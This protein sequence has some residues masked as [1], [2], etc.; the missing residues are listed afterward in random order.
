MTEKDRMPWKAAEK[1]AE[2]GTYKMNDKYT[3][4]EISRFLNISKSA[5]RYY[6]SIGLCEPAC[7]DE[8]TG[9][10]YYEYHQFFLLNMIGKFKKMRLSLDQIKAHSRIKNV[11]SLEHLL[12]ER[13]E[14]LRKELEELM[15]LDRQNEQLLQKIETS[16]AAR[17]NQAIEL[18][19]IP[20]RFLYRLNINFSNEDLYAYIKILYSSYIKNIDREPA[21]E[22]GDIALEI[23]RDNLQK[24]QFHTYNSIGFFVENGEALG[25][26]RL[27]EIPAGTYAVA[28]HIGR[29][30]T[31]AK[32][33]R[34]LEHYIRVSHMEIIGN[35][36]ETSLINISMTN[37]PD[38][39]VTEIQIPVGMAY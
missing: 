12:L 27:A 25:A 7:R 18:R 1:L 17:R 24:R 14:I 4:A 11:A 39:F 32:T 22:K 5:L 2:G 36:V 37:N 30:D 15:A 31:I 35:S 21:Y 16:N 29:Y 19:Q 28:C 6:D 10:R 26:S 38:E 9:Y 33:Y 20:R 23:S 34:K 3:I 8:K 13:R